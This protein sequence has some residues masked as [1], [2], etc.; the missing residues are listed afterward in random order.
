MKIH[1]LSGKMIDAR[2]IK[3]LLGYYLRDW[4]SG[5]YPIENWKGRRS[6]TKTWRKEIAMMGRQR[7]HQHRVNAMRAAW[8][9]RQT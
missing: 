6:P 1:T 9:R 4:R 5:K 7:N 3:R 2:H 8:E